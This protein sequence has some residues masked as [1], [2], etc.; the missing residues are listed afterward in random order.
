MNDVELQG[1]IQVL[2]QQRNDALDR[3]TSLGGQLLVA[4]EELQKLKNPT[5]ET[6][7]LKEVSG[8]K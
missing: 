6:S 5:D 7:K 4:L 8:K 2:T 1:Q 3:A